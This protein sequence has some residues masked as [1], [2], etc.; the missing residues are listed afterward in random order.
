[1]VCGVTEV[2]LLG[3]AGAHLLPIYVYLFVQAHTHESQACGILGIWNLFSCMFQVGLFVF[4]AVYE[5]QFPDWEVK[6]ASSLEQS[7]SHQ[8]LGRSTLIFEA[9]LPGIPCWQNNKPGL[10]TPLVYGLKQL[11]PQWTSRRK[12]QVSGSNW[13][14][15]RRPAS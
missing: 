10:F 7:L 15:G 5:I 13:G 14:F 9:V 11:G 1:M 12:P 4:K 6:L 2:E 8:F 3:V